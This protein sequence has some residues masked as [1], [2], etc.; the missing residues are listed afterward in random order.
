MILMHNRVSLR[1]FSRFSLSVR[2]PFCIEKTK[3]YNIDDCTSLN[4]M[5]SYIAVIGM[6]K[7]ET[8][9]EIACKNLT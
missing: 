1:T 4:F 2:M 5:P 9:S 6:A 7:N 8:L 3:S